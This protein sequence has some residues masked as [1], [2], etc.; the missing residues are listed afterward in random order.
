METRNTLKDLLYLGVGTVSL[1]THKVE[2]LTRKLIEQ[3]KVTRD[4]GEEIVKAYIRKAEQ[5]KKE[6]TRKKEEVVAF[7]DA[8]VEMSKEQIREFFDQALEKPNEAKENIQ[9]KVDL[10]AK[11]L[12]DKTKM[13]MD[14]GKRLIEGF[15]DELRQ[16]QES[17][18][19][20]VY[21]LADELNEK[22]KDWKGSS[23]SFFKEMDEKAHVIGNELKTSI[24][25][26]LE[27]LKDRLHVA[28]SEEVKDLEERVSNLEKK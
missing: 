5:A 24:Y 4:E 15:I 6:I 12:S 23:Q 14:E 11:Q 7:I 27:K 1:A 25:S 18:S 21:E 28:S 9:Q 10:L 2:E 26:S 19:K 22:M 16:H 17:V 20:K 8:R 3:H 13:S